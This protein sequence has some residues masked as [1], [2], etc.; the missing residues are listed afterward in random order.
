M[1]FKIG[2][3]V[4]FLN[5]IGGGVVTKIISPTMVEVATEDD[6]TLPMLVSELLFAQSQDLK[7]SV[8]NQDFQVNADMENTSETAEANEEDDWAEMEKSSRLPKL[9]SLN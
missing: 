3:K 5:D 6:F 2:D 7:E 4:K 9:S 1:K 8:F